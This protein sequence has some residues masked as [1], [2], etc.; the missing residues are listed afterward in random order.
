MPTYT[1]ECKVHGRR[2]VKRPMDE[3]GDPA[4]CPQCVREW[5]RLGPGEELEDFAFAYGPMRRIY[6]PQRIIVRPRGYN[7]KPGEYAGNGLGYSFFDYELERGELRDDAS[8]AYSPESRAKREA[9]IAASD[10]YVPRPMAEID[11]EIPHQ[12]H[13][14]L[15]EWARVVHAQLTEEDA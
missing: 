11:R 5:V 10:V 4:Y 7:L 2:D 3:A 1:F 13:Q 14:E 12:A 9:E 15:H 8:G 6:N